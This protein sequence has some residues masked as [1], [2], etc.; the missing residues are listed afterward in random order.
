MFDFALGRIDNLPATIAFL[1]LLYCKTDGL[2]GQSGG[3]LNLID[4][5]LLPLTPVMGCGSAP[6]QPQ[7]VTDAAE[8]CAI[9]FSSVHQQKQNIR[10]RWRILSACQSLIETLTDHHFC[11][12]WRS[13]PSQ[14]RP[15]G[16]HRHAGSR[17]TVRLSKP[18]A[19]CAASMLL[20]QKQ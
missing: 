14:I 8:R 3:K 7:E 19:R 6:L 20:G 18:T 9:H 10:G 16:Q 17:S 15:P 1:G 12:G 11:T 13:W 2:V 4:L 5:S